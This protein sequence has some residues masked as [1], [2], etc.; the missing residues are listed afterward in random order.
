LKKPISKKIQFISKKIRRYSKAPFFYLALFLVL[1]L[2]SILFLSA[3]TE[4]DNL[5]SVSLNDKSRLLDDGQ[6]L[7]EENLSES[8]DLSLNIIGEEQL[9]A[10][11]PPF[12]VSGRVL[13][14]WGMGKAEEISEYVVQ[15]NDSLSSIAK[16]FNI[17]LETILWANDLNK[18]SAISPGQKLIILP[19]SG[20]LHIIR[21]GD[22]L[23]EIAVLYQADLEDVLDFNAIFDEEAIY[24]GDKLIIPGGKQP[25][26]TSVSHQSVPLA[27][28][29]FIC[30]LPAPCRITQGLH[31]YNAIDFSNGRCGDPV[32]A[33]AGG[34]IQKKGYTQLGGNFVRISHP[35]GVITY[36]GHLSKNIVEVG[37]KIFQGQIVGYV[38]NSGHTI[39]SDHRGCHLHFDVIFAEN[40]F[41]RYQVGTCLGQ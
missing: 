24:P 37:Q 13:G 25:T 17:S 29:Y 19:V 38:G 14:S 34:I 31:W 27:D 32:F 4:F 8:S 18:R 22:V 11:A 26:V 7:F 1:V 41:A 16:D 9:S 33:A 39:P 2:A 28:S 30:P 5:S 23:S 20:V 21:K 15:D 12:S 6:Y 35:N 3:D 10:V 36:Y 40:P